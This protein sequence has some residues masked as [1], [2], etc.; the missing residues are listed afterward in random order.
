MLWLLTLAALCVFGWAYR[1]A[2]RADREE[3]ATEEAWAKGPA[4]L[5]RQEGR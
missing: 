1:D 3:I 4:L 2:A 5:H